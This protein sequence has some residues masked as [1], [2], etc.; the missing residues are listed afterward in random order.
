[1]LLFPLRFCRELEIFHLKVYNFIEVLFVHVVGLF[2]SGK[3]ADIQKI[4]D[5]II[6]CI[7]CF[8]CKPPLVYE[9]LLL[10]VLFITI[11][12]VAGFRDF[13]VHGEGDNYI[14]KIV[15]A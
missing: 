4:T 13:S 9:M 8:H 5:G 14:T 3:C 1:M 6:R 7:F 10:T 11:L 15:T 12:N 2:L